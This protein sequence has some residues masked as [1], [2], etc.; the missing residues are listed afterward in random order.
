M[1]IAERKAR[2]NQTVRNSILQA[3]R[4][5]AI[6]D[7]WR[8]VSVRRITRSIE[9]STAIIYQHFKGGKDEL[10]LT[11]LRDGF[12]LM[13][14]RI[15]KAQ[16]TAFERELQLSN[17]SI[18]CW[19]FALEYPELYQVM[20]NLEGVFVNT[21]ATAEELRKTARPAMDI[22]FHFTRNPKELEE[23]FFNW[24]AIVH[25]II[26]ITMSRQLPSGVALEAADKEQKEL[27]LRKAVARF[28]M[29]LKFETG[30]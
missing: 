25:G 26:S 1:G 21:Q 11:L 22:L 6:E 16:G 29:G 5:L 27:Y 19:S 23:A 2:H 10:L 8:S 3:A 28:V 9:Y 7:G 20:F 18:A 30:A 15:E 17:I 14:K 12:E 4:R 24:W 13:R